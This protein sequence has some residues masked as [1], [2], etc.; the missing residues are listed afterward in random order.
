VRWHAI[1]FAALF[2]AAFTAVLVL[3]AYRSVALLATAL[4]V[5]VANP[6]LL[7]FLRQS[8]SPRWDLH[9]VTVLLISCPCVY[10][11]TD[12]LAPKFEM[13]RDAYFVTTGAAIAFVTSSNARESLKT[14][15]WGRLGL[16]SIG[17]SIGLLIVVFTLSFIV[18][19]V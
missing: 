10:L 12:G 17:Y 4:V 15:N 19:L 5:F 14:K 16:S 9:V 13:L 18:F 6:T 2:S 7:G 3:Y 11:I 1:A 8:N